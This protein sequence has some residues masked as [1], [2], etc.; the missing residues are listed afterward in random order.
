MIKI[1]NTLTHTKEKFIP[2]ILNKVGMYVCGVTVYDLCHIGHGRT[3]VV[4][5]MIARYFRYR[6]YK[7]KYV[8]NITDIDDKI[9]QRAREKREH[10]KLFTTHIIREMNNDFLALN[11]LPP[12][13]EPLATNHIK[14]II[15]IINDLFHHNYAY[16]ADNGDIFFDVNSYLNY[17][18]LSRQSLKNLQAT[19]HSSHINYKRNPMDFVLWK[20]KIHNY[21][22][23]WPS[24]WG[25][26]RPGWHIECSAMNKKYLGKHFDIHGGGLDLIF[27]HHENEIAQSCCIAKNS[28]VNYWI[29]SGMMLME[30]E[31]M[32]KSSNNY[33]TIRQL[34]K[35]YHPESIRF[36]LLSSHYRRTLSYS[37]LRIKE[38]HNALSRLYTAL[39]STQEDW[40]ESIKMQKIDLFRQKFLNAMDDDFNTPAAYSVLFELAREI[41]IYKKKNIPSVVKRLA[42]NLRF[43]GGILG[44]LQHSPR[45]FLQSHYIYSHKKNEE[46]IIESLIM[47]RHEARKRK[48]WEQADLCRKQLTNMG[49]I[50]E[51]RP[52]GTTWRRN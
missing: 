40:N 36:F 18:V 19:T 30:S 22:P 34:L 24:P 35:Y 42:T 28:Y 14:D 44:I 46:L 4:F 48:N 23:S 43:L 10:I 41:N 16:L 13:I 47:R 45:E 8:R 2:I 25:E 5:D 31:K 50:L 49:I 7:L 20:K 12:D 6:G 52:S 26:G 27:P 29:H 15:Q 33:L 1:Y 37:D 17:G 39:S 9:I 11:I 38:A 3:F 51:D 32:S 21:E